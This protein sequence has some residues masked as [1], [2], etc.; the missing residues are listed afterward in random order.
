MLVQL[1]N[2]SSSSLLQVITVIETHTLYCVNVEQQATAV[3]PVYKMYVMMTMTQLFVTKVNRLVI[4]LRFFFFINSYYMCLCFI[5]SQECFMNKE[6]HC[7]NDD[8]NPKSITN[9]NFRSKKEYWILNHKSH[10][11]KNTCAKFDWKEKFFD[12]SNFG[13]FF[14]VLKEQ[15]KT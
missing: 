9:W 1:Q 11:S 8:D 7:Q 3:R 13:W 15:H 5:N 6:L 2:C 14:S 4:L 12:S 10:C